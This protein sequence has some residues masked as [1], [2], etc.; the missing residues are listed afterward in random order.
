L[1]AAKEVTLRKYEGAKVMESVLSF[2][3]PN[4][5]T[6]PFV[7][8][9]G[10]YHTSREVAALASAGS[11]GL[12]AFVK[13]GSEAQAFEKHVQEHYARQGYPETAGASA[14]G[15]GIYKVDPSSPFPDKRVHALAGND[16]ILDDELDTQHDA[17]HEIL[18]PMLDHSVC[19]EN[20][21]LLGFGYAVPNLSTWPLLLL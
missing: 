14:F 2:A 18:A 6:W 13:P 5:S 16:T 1:K 4:A 12:V 17:R 8:L 20:L 15:F 21:R 9:N 3:F 19:F 7:A 11:M 10:Y